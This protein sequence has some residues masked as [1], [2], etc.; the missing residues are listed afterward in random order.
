MS[1][2]T[3]DSPL[4]HAKINYSELD[5]LNP[6]VNTSDFKIYGYRWIIALI[7]FLNLFASGIHSATYA[8]FTPI[9]QKA[10]DVPTLEATILQMTYTIT[11]LFMN[12]V[13]S[14]TIDKKGLK[15]A[16]ILSSGLLLIGI[17]IRMAVQSD[18]TGFWVLILAQVFGGAGQAFV[19]S[20]PSKM[21]MTWFPK[22]EHAKSTTLI[23]LAAPIG[24]II[25]MGVPPLFIDDQ[26]ENTLIA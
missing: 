11:I 3:D 17:W 13:A 24:C 10:F 22:H 9:L 26:Q 18:G 16:G 15:L 12:F 5:P 1:V 19:L 14:M 20:S 21:S 25:G 8:T 23:A 4:N 6:T 7:I 2:S